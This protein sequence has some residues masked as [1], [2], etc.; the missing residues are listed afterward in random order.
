MDTVSY[1]FYDHLADQLNPSGLSNLAN[2]FEYQ[3]WNQFIHRHHDRRILIAVIIVPGKVLF[4]SYDSK[5]LTSKDLSRYHRLSSIQ[6]SPKAPQAT[7]PH[8]FEDFEKTLNALISLI[9][10]GTVFKFLGQHNHQLQG[11]LSE[12]PFTLLILRNED[13][14]SLDFINKQVLLNRLKD[15]ELVGHCHHEALNSLLEDLLVQN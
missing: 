6:V 3:P 7:E 15:V 11:P 9:Y 2:I 12:V 14:L 4:Q 5:I 8:E 10:P 13:D 1:Y